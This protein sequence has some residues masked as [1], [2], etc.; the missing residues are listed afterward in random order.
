MACDERTSA[1][2]ARVFTAL[3]YSSEHHPYLA[4][5]DFT[6]LSAVPALSSEKLTTGIRPGF[7]AWTDE[8]VVKNYQHT[9]SHQDPDNSPRIALGPTVRLTLGL[10]DTYCHEAPMNVDSPGVFESLRPQNP[11]VTSNTALRSH[12]YPTCGTR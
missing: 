6:R 3:G 10:K 11:T 8:S 9:T 1:S 4:A 5:S 2:C 12:N 7:R